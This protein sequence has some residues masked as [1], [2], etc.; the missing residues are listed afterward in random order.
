MYGE[1]RLGEKYDIN[2]WMT[3]SSS[4]FDSFFR[5]RDLNSKIY[6]RVPVPRIS[7]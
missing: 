1:F 2:D 5:S 6:S 7:I 4:G 3:M